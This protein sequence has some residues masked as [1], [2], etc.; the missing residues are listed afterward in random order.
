MIITFLS[1]NG[2]LFCFVSSCPRISEKKKIVYSHIQEMVF[3]R[4][5]IMTVSLGLSASSLSLKSGLRTFLSEIMK[6]LLVQEIS[7]I[8]LG[9]RMRAAA[10][11]PRSGEHESRLE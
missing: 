1:E 10:R 2:L 5:L 9:M 6:A 4:R 11:E 3:K 8:F 7:L